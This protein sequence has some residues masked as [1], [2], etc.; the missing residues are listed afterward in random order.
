M[1]GLWKRGGKR[2]YGGIKGNDTC[3][4]SELCKSFV[5]DVR[6]D[7]G[8]SGRVHNAALRDS[9]VSGLRFTLCATWKH[10]TATTD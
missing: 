8:E 9:P 4:H 1:F 7:N 5:S 10:G 6:T 3:I 2:C